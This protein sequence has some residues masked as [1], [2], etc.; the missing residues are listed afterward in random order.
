MVFRFWRH[1]S[2]DAFNLK[3]LLGL[4]GE[5]ADPLKGSF[6]LTLGWETS[7]VAGDT[8]RRGEKFSACMMQAV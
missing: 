8:K 4:R 3:V 5:E 6:S 7:S 2:G 1:G